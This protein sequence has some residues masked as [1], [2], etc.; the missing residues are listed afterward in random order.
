MNWTPRR[1]LWWVSGFCRAVE[2]CSAE[3]RES[4]SL[5]RGS[6]GR[7]KG[8]G[9][10]KGRK[11]VKGAESSRCGDFGGCAT[12]GRKEKTHEEE[13]CA[14]CACDAYDF[15]VGWLCGRFRGGPFSFRARMPRDVGA[16]RW[17][18]RPEGRHEAVRT[19]S[20]EAHCERRLCGGR[21]A[22]H[23]DSTHARSISDHPGVRHLRF[24][25]RTHLRGGERLLWRRVAPV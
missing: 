13:T 18:A 8:A 1:R 21:R 5:Q 6:W 7:Q 10:F 20:P 4:A 22:E 12:I 2:R 11:E 15:A 25:R 14:R 24:S 9:Y 23:V 17:R 3:R 16:G 19:L